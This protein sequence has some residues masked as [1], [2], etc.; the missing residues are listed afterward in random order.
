MGFLVQHH[1]TARRAEYSRHVWLHQRHDS[2]T[3]FLDLTF[4]DVAFISQLSDNLAQF[5]NKGRFAMA[6][7]PAPLLWRKINDARPY[8]GRQFR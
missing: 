3:E 5:V 8:R 7:V 4:L 1:D 2:V 6:H